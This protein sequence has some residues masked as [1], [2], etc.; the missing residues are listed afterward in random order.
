MAENIILK[1]EFEGADVTSQKAVALSTNLNKLGAQ[2]RNLAKQIKNLDTNSKTYT[3]DLQR[4]ITE[5]NRVNAEIKV[6]K[7]EYANYERASINATVAN[8]AQNGSLNQMRAQLA[9]AQAQWGRMTVAQQKNSKEGVALKQRIDQLNTTVKGGEEA[10]G[11]HNRSVGDYGKALNGLSPYLGQFGSQISMVQGLL[12]EIS[13]QLKNFG[14]GAGKA[15]STV[16]GF[17]KAAEG[18]SDAISGV[19]SAVQ[20]STAATGSYNTVQQTTNATMAQGRTV[21]AGYAAGQTAAATATKGATAAS[22]GLSKA[23]KIVRIALISTGIGAIVVVIGSLIA[24]V[25]ST[26]KGMDAMTRVI[27]PVKEVF[28]TLFGILQDVGVTAFTMLKAAFTIYINQFVLGYQL[29]KK[30]VLEMRVAWNEWTGDDLEAAELKKE[31]AEVNK[32]IKETTDEMKQSAIDIANGFKEIAKTAG[33]AGDRVAEAYDRGNVMADLK[34]EIEQMEILQK[35]REAEL[36]LKI[37][38][39]RRDRKNAALSNAERAKAEKDEIRFTEQQRNLQID[40]IKKR[41][42]LAEL[43]TKAND[44]DNAAKQ[45]IA[46][47]QADILLKEAQLQKDITRI[48]QEGNSRRKKEIADIRKAK[49]EAAAKEVKDEIDALN[50]KQ[51]L[52]ILERKLEIAIT[53]ETNEERYN[54][55]VELQK[56]LFDLKIAAAKKAGEDT[57]IL[58]KE[59]QIAIAELNKAEQDRIAEEGKGEAETA[60]AKKVK[61]KADELKIEKDKKKAKIGLAIQAAEEISKGLFERSEKRIDEE[62]QRE[63]DSL[64]ARMDAGEITQK[65]FDKKRE[66]IDKKAFKRKKRLDTA[67]VIVN[68]LVAASKTIAQLGFFNP[69]LPFALA[70]VGIQTAGQIAGI[71]AQTFADGGFTG[72]SSAAPDH[73]GQRPVGVVHENEFVANRHA[74]ST[75]L[76]SQLAS[77]LNA[78]NQNPALGYFAEGGFTSRRQ[79]ID[80]QGLATAIGGQMQSIR[81]VNVA[82]ET[83]AV[84]GRTKFVRNKGRI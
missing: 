48:S 42:E 55:E 51:Q 76:G 63:I 56:R 52:L 72:T 26:Q 5:Q 28:A 23:L 40:L 6:G 11:V 39:A 30:G 58:E 77:T 22:G 75:P 18:S 25:A 32:D 65:E 14:V 57:V 16:Q 41:L 24:A 80:E 10:M 70:G 67:E 68:G 1:V 37:E 45:E 83:S 9:S 59:K 71:Q 15:R 47:M 81:V 31:L 84:D 21:V 12:G 38:T 50:K 64:K 34:I 66:A 3:A 43:S 53:Q 27:T 2:K 29:F 62:K 78:I 20:G 19:T 4:L 60:A 69:L 79:A 33:E 17:G 61:D 82:S 44:T 46:D 13:K 7:K 54:S 36:Q 74:L 73:T 49:E 35:K 8:R